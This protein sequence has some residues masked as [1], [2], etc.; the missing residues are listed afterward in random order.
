MMLEGCV[1]RSPCQMPKSQI[2]TGT[3]D[4]R[5]LQHFTPTKDGGGEEHTANS[6]AKLTGLQLSLADVVPRKRRFIRARRAQILRDL[7]AACVYSR[8]ERRQSTES[9]SSRLG[10]AHRKARIRVRTR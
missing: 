1:D 8:A 2:L 9:I 4:R 3:C 10:A 7:L 6:G 5:A